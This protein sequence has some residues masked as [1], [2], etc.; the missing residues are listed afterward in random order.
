M[1]QVRGARGAGIQKQ[2]IH[3]LCKVFRV[4]FMGGGVAIFDLA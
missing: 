4:P 3:E 2:G 1:I